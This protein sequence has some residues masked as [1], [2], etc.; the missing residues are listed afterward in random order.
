MMPP[1]KPYHKAMGYGM[2]GGEAHFSGNEYI[3]FK[4][5]TAEGAINTVLCLNPTASDY[6]PPHQFVGTKFNNVAEDAMAFIMS[7]PAGWANPTDC[8]EFPCSAPL[9]I[10]FDFKDTMFSPTNPFNYGSKFQVIANNEGFSPYVDGCT[11]KEGMNAYVCKKEHL[12][13]MMFE[14]GDA[15]TEDRTMSPIYLSLKGTK[16]ANKLNSMMDHMWDGFYTGQI[17][18]SRF[19]GIVDAIP[20]SVYNLTFTG[21][22]AQKMRFKLMSQSKTAGI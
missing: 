19:P 8:V 6:V 11:K 14:S 21:S 10:L 5:K 1:L 2:W 20:K 15:D 7:P 3:N 9:N 12:S 17:H 18:L 13:V 16:M 4:A 22:P